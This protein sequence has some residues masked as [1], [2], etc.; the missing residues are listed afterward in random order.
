MTTRIQVF[1][2][3]MKET[4]YANDSRGSSENWVGENNEHCE[5]NTLTSE[6]RPMYDPEFVCEQNSWTTHVEGNQDFTLRIRIRYSYRFWVNSQK[7]ILHIMDLEFPFRPSVFLAGG[8]QI[9][10]MTDDRPAQKWVRSFRRIQY[11]LHSSTD[12][13]I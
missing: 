5:I 3:A 9:L 2:M 8:K 6:E 12:K 1:S 4:S 7:R 11:I 13:S 10:V